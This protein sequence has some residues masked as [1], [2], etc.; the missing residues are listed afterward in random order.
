MKRHVVLLGDST[1]DNGA[2]TNGGPDV[3]RHLRN[4]IERD[5]VVVSLARDGAVCSSIE[6]Q[7]ARFDTA[8]AL[9]RAR[10]EQ[11]DMVLSVGGN[12]ALRSMDLVDGRN[13]GDSRGV[14]HELGQ[15][16][17]AFEVDYRCAVKM[18]LFLGLPLTVC[19]IYNGNFPAEMANIARVALMIFNDVIIRVAADVGCGLIDL[20][21]VC[22]E[23][24]DYYNPIEPSNVGGRKIAAAIMEALR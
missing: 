2:Y 16:S 1:I 19:T 8:V 23:P 22:R 18:A 13:Y 15:R 3:R 9:F 6:S 7:V 21:S 24:G 12:D 20:R 17:A 14:L 5:T 11:F 10:P 4:M